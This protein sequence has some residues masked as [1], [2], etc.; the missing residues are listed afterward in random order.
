MGGDSL[1]SY[2]KLNGADEEAEAKRM[3]KQIDDKEKL[4]KYW[5]KVRRAFQLP[6]STDSV[7]IGQAANSPD[8]KSEVDAE[9]IASLIDNQVAPERAKEI[10]TAIWKS[11]QAIAELANE[12]RFRNE[13]AIHKTPERLSAR[14][15]ELLL[16]QAASK[17]DRLD[18]GT[19]RERT[20][21]P[22]WAFPLGTVALLLFMLLGAFAIYQFGL[23]RPVADPQGKDPV[24]DPDKSRSNGDPN[25]KEN[26]SLVENG[27]PAQDDEDQ[28]NLKKKDSSSPSKSPDSG[29]KENQIV[30]GPNQEI[31]KQFESWSKN[32]EPVEYESPVPDAKPVRVEWQTVRGMLAVR[33]KDKANY[34]YLYPREPKVDDWFRILPG[35][36]VRGE[37]ADVASVIANR[38]TSFRVFSPRNESEA[39]IAVGVEYGQIALQNLARKQKVQLTSGEKDWPIEIL[40][41]RTTLALDASDA[42]KPRLI[43]QRGAARFRDREVKRGWQVT[44]SADANYTVSKA[45]NA[46]LG[47]VSK[48]PKGTISLNEESRKRLYSSGDLSHI[49]ANSELKF[50]GRKDLEM[51]VTWNLSLNPENVYEL[52]H[53][54]DSK[55]RMAVAEW[56]VDQR[57]SN[58]VGRTAWATT[59]RRTGEIQLV[60]TLYQWLLQLENNRQVPIRAAAEK[61]SGLL[62][63]REPLIRYLA[64]HWYVKRFGN[65]FQYHPDAAPP[66]RTRAIGL[67]RRGRK[68]NSAQREFP[69]IR[70]WT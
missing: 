29:I 2:R 14:V 60:R 23:D 64:G 6:T 40:E 33:S 59:A 57:I 22:R 65:P 21:I 13:L 7:G 69:Q 50:S 56:L 37:I 28:N 43:V 3:R 41:D 68:N 63:H 30:E 12:L 8:A 44:Y 24:D 20:Q 49:F 31:I 38:D 67:W 26:P 39:S 19:E 15:D 42:T 35:S 45:V 54:E 5:R 17:V 11:E 66:K 47:W 62:N 70:K 55:V 58:G 16:D 9:M 52:S 48:P 34:G 46:N 4:Q 27:N 1:V 25:N 18:P 53:H 10:E 36:W 61:M 32:D 51:Q